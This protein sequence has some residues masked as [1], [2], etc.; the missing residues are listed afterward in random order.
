VRD[1]QDGRA[2]LYA[3]RGDWLQQQDLASRDPGRAEELLE[4]AAG[5]QRLHDYVLLHDRLVP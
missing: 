1:P 3:N 4:Q 5:V 2:R